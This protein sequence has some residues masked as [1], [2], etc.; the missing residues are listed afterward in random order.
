[1]S[2][3]VRAAAERLL[4]R[5][6]AK[7]I[8]DD[9]ES[10]MGRAHRFWEDA[11]VVAR[12]YLA[13]HPETPPP[14]PPLTDAFRAAA[15]IEAATP[16]AVGVTARPPVPPAVVE[17]Y[18]RPIKGTPPWSGWFEVVEKRPPVDFGEV[19]FYPVIARCDNESDAELLAHGHAELERLREACRITALMRVGCECGRCGPCMA[20]I[21]L[22]ASRP[23]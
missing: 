13:E 19:P 17:R 21:A 10:M 5:E 11:D 12:T 6:H 4:A 8:P 3:D 18:V 9:F 20:R 2:D 1:M 15:D 14:V 7:S 23:T 16:I 22:A